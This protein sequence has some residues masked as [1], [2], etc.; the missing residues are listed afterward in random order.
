MLEGLAPKRNSEV[1]V[2]MRKAAELDK[3]DFDILM[4]A[5]EDSS[6]SSNGLAQALRQR[7]FV[8]HKN[9]INEHRKKVCCCVR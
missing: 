3:A 1:C 9:A 5:I 8:A 7:G 4:D 6:W 2:I